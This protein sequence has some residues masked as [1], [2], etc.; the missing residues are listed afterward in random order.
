MIGQSFGPYRIVEKLGDGGMGVVYRAQDVRLHRD[1]AVKFL[2]PAFGSASQPIDRLLREAQAASALSHPHICAVF[3]VGQAGDQ[4]FI[5]MELLD[6]TTLARHA[7]GRAL[8]VPSLLRWGTQIADALDTAHAKGVVHRD[9]K[10]GNVF[11]TARGDAK[12]VDFGLAKFVDPQDGSSPERAEVMTRTALTEPGTPMGSAAYMSPEQVRGQSL[13]GRTD[14][15]SLGILLYELAT[16]ARPFAGGTGADVAAAILHEIP[17]APT[18]LNPRL[19]ARFDD[20]VGKL[21][22][23]DPVLRY[24]S[25]G[26]VRTDL[27]RL[28]RDLDEQSSGSHAGLRAK[29]RWR[30]PWVGLLVASIA[31]AVWLGVTVLR[32]KAPAPLTDRDTVLLADVVN[33]TGEQVFDDA[34]KQALALQ[35]EQSPFLALLSEAQLRETLRLMGRKTDDR[36]EGEVARDICQRR[37]AAAVLSTSIQTIGGSYVLDLTATNCAT[38]GSV[39]REQAQAAT[40]AD[41]L[42]AVGRAAASLR[43]KLGESLAS[44]QRFDVPAEDVTTSSLEA[45]KAFSLGERARTRGVEGEGIPFY[46]RALELDPDFALAHQRL[47]TIYR[48]RT[49]LQLAET[50]AREA[51][52]RREGVSTRERLYI[53]ARY[54]TSVTGDLEKAIETLRVLAEMYPRDWSAANQLA[55][56]SALLGRHDDALI[57][58]LEALRRGPDH[59]LP[60]GNLSDYYRRVERLQDSASQAQTVVARWGINSTNLFAAGFVLQRRDLMDRART[61]MSDVDR[62]STDARIAAFAGRWSAARKAYERVDQTATGEVRALYAAEYALFAAINGDVREATRAAKQAAQADHPTARAWSGVALALVNAKR[63]AET[64]GEQLAQK[65]PTDTLVQ[66]I[67]IPSLRAAVALGTGDG[68]AATKHLVP[69]VPYELGDRVGMLC[70]L[71]IYLRAEAYRLLGEGQQSASE[72]RKIVDRPG[73]NAMSPLWPLAQLGLARALAL[74]GDAENARAA[75]GRFFESWRDADP[76]LRPF[77]EATTELTRLNAR[78]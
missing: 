26:D 45:L 7:A 21:L 4:P 70:C 14:L 59:P 42:P 57:A 61:R 17:Q 69:A 31:V 71:P 34:L 16:G 38:G 6:G 32:S 24:R 46:Q 54:H 48:N 53:E 78:R 11:I 36:V 75:Y 68:A 27:E 58:G 35:L 52:A 19:P 63:E 15:F 20:I 29:R 41:V 43:E 30:P 55:F 50:H 44:I 40:S 12:I 25:A 9:L 72:F 2:S 5:V 8:D 64:I 74:Q 18:R 33:R 13:D 60:N 23:K 65:Y 77:R 39:A 28:K 1:V 3:D 66:R 22:E 56:N 49:R 67:G 47:A 10:P 73:L 76:S 62:T 37:G 51:F